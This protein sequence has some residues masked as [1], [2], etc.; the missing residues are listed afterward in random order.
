VVGEYVPGT[1]GTMQLERRHHWG[2]W[3][4]DLVAEEIDTDHDR[5][6]ETTLTP[7]TDLLG[8]VELLTDSSGRIVERITYDPDGTPHVFGEDT[9]RPTITRI[10][11]TGN[12]TGPAGTVA[13]GVLEI[14]LSE[15]IDEASLARLVATL[16][17]DGGVAQTL[18]ASLTPDRRGLVL[19]GGSLTA[20]QPATLHLAGLADPT[21]NVSFPLE[22]TLAVADVEAYA[23]LAD[24]APPKLTAVLDTT[25]G[26]LLAFDE[27]V[28]AVPGVALGAAV[29]LMRS[30][31]PLDGTTTRLA[32]N[33]LQWTPTPGGAGS[34]W[35]LGGE[36]RFTEARLTDTSAEPKPLAAGV[37]PLP[38]TH[39][40]TEVTKPLAAYAAPTDSHPR[41]SSAYG[42]TTLFQGRTWHPDLGLYHYRARWYDP[43][44]ANFLERDPA[45]DQDSPSRYQG[46]GFNSPNVL[47]PA[48]EYEADVHYGLT[49]YL[50]VEA[51]YSR[52]EAAIVA[53]HDL[54][55]DFNPES[56]PNRNAAEGNWEPVFE[57]HFPIDPE[58]G[59]VVPG[60][61]VAH[62]RVERARS[63]AELGT[64]LHV[65]QDSY[66]H[67][68]AYRGNIVEQAQAQGEIEGATI[69]AGVRVL[70]LAKN[71]KE[72][73]TH[74]V[75]PEW[76]ERF[77]LKAAG[78]ATDWTFVEPAIARSCAIATFEALI[79]YRLRSKAISKSTTGVLSAR[80]VFLAPEVAEFVTADTIA[81]KRAWLEEHV[82]GVVGGMPWEDVSLPLGP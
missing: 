82:P 22:E 20:G 15:P 11:W 64:G 52:G 67:R 14:S 54:L 56:H 31:L 70:G 45:G 66:G 30:G 26:L 6:L 55:T 41:A 49:F 51:G 23:V 40:T 47:D 25:D 62:S 35:Q 3:I 21:G 43:T 4:D 1:D 76:T 28:V 44:L 48:G 17:P 75:R 81:A 39:L 78:H 38:V 58:T 46:M 73:V 32:P 27:P 65:L 59:R 69:R 24:T 7:I 50:A 72:G 12:G 33:V 80:W 19:S 9:T 74:E 34:A 13:A 77:G 10:A 60:S 42:L 29:T 18:T 16:T 57:Y 63:L 5:S 2:R 71:Q 79:G 37:L 61:P 8:N 68:N 53:N 36:V